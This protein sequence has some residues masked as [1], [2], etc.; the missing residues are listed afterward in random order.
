MHVPRAFRLL[1]PLALT[2]GLACAAPR[3]PDSDQQVLETLP[4]RPAD[5]RM[6]QVNALRLELRR[7][8]DD[9]A[10]AV[11]LARRYYELV[12]AEGDPRFVGQAQSALAPWWD[13]PD[14]PPAVRVM[15]AVLL[16]FGHRFDEAVADLSAVVRSEP[17]NAQAWAWL[18][19]IHLVQADYAEAR[20][21][22][23]RLAPHTTPL[24]ATTCA[25]H[26]DS[27]TGQAARASQAIRAALRDAPAADAEAR[28][29]TLTRLAEIDE[30]RGD[31]AAAEAAFR[32]ALSLGLT[33]GYL[34]AAY[35]DFLLDRGRAGEVLTLLK[36]HGRSDV[37]LLRLALAARLLNAPGAA[38][39]E[40]DMAARFDAARLRGDATHQKEEARFALGVQN[41]PQRSLPLAADN[42]AVQREPADARILLEAALAARRPDAAAPALQWMA[43]S[44]IESVV[45]HGLATRLEALR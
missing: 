29:W 41:Q 40:R 21:A 28:L 24:L 35:A 25:A 26:V 13:R 43:A 19:A 39:F 27:L 22:C 23:G 14:P 4:V 34:L 44:R 7:H 32:D 15:R 11:A 33:D 2:A 5:P 10:T 30:R 18:A 45:L 38:A 31:H 3:V 16:Q 42:F 36:E 37:L 12:A 20:V 8:P 1:I 9:V 6:A 17:G